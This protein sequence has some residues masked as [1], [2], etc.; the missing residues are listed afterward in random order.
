VS[1]TTRD[2]CA[3]PESAGATV[4]AGAGNAA[5]AVV[6]IDHLLTDP[7]TFVAVTATPTNFATS[8]SANT[9]VDDVAPEIAVQP[10]GR[11]FAAAVT[12]ALQRT[13]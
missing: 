11:A 13:H 8:V 4:F 9:Y 7:M 12:R 5:T 10:A 3:L 6:V 2:T 1:D